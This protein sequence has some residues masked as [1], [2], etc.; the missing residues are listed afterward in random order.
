MRGVG[1]DTTGSTPIPVDRRNVPLALRP[2]G[3]RDEL[4]RDERGCGRTTPR[5]PEAAEIC[6]KI[7]ALGRPVPDDVR[8]H[9]LVR[10][11]LGEDPPLRAG[12]PAK[13]RRP[14]GRGSSS[15]TGSRRTSA[16]WTDPAA[17][18]RAASARRATRR[19]IT[20][21]WGG[22]AGR[23]VLGRAAAGA[24][25]LTRAR[26]GSRRP[27]RIA[28]AGRTL[29]AARRR[30]NSGLRAEAGRRSRSVRRA[31]RRR[32]LRRRAGHAREDHRHGR[33]ATCTVLP[34]W[35]ARSAEIPGV[36]GVVPE[37]ILPGHHGIEAGQSAVGDLF[38]WFVS[39]FG[40]PGESQGDDASA[41][42]APS[43]KGSAP[44]KAAFSR[45]TGTTATA[46]CWSIRGC[47]G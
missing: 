32:R 16:A 40:R 6:A 38:N 4:G 31:P 10:V 47:R 30:E 42:H 34:L 43:R 8:R 35:N 25:A 37:S 2:D 1:I 45:S 20:R 26:S 36:C 28:S 39:K 11:V 14:R 41:F 33:A 21:Q 7:K 19:S 5:T 9:V 24:L 17:D 15:A 23:R 27:P 46:A 22:L 29:S 12:V 44:D 13:S 3:F 18:P